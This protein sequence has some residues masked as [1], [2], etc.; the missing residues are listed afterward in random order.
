MHPAHHS[1]R[2]PGA[3][4]ST[5]LGALL[6]SV[7][8]ATATHATA[9]DTRYPV[10]PLRMVVPF[11][12]GGGTDLIGRTVAAKL[13]DGLGQQIVVDNRPGAGGVNGTELVARAAPDG[14]T[15][16]L[17]FNG[18]LTVSPHLMKTP[19]D[20][21]RD[22]VGLDLMASSYH[23]LAVHPSVQARTVK[24]LVAL[25]RS[26]PG[27]LHYASS[28]S[29]TNL[30]LT[31]ELF[32]L[33]AGIDLVHLPY[34][35]T[36]P[37]ATAVL[38]G[39]AQMIFS[40]LTAVLPQVRA[41]RLAGLAVTSPQRSPL[42]PEFP[43]LAESGYAE[44][45]VRSWYTPLVPAR[46]PPAVVER[47]RTELVRVAAAADVRE[48]LASQAIDVQTLPAGEYARFLQ[49]E[50]DKWGKVVRSAGIRAE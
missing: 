8:G 1:P 11:T 43:T 39:E 47:L 23:M 16:L 2:R 30:H 10:R 6:V 13:G 45:A 19:Y 27:K 33:V 38:S 14:Y 41:G 3:N 34:K 42:A 5:L 12:P 28:G 7:V 32:K 15:L 24:E 21:V 40:A 49:A 50:L 48:R 35:G 20:P 44:V 9:A 18:L 31:A 36:A 29:G 46:T 26:R 37:A 4:G 25:A 17:G 22:F